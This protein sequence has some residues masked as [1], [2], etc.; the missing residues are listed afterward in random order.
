MIRPRTHPP[1]ENESKN[2]S[3]ATTRVFFKARFTY[4]HILR[5][6]YRN[7]E[8]IHS[9][10]LPL[11]RRCLPDLYPWKI[12]TKRTRTF[13]H[14]FR[15]QGLERTAARRGM[16]MPSAAGC[17]TQAPHGRSGYPRNRETCHSGV[18]ARAKAGI[19]GPLPVAPHKSSGGRRRLYDVADLSRWTI[20]S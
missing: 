7:E 12:P 9:Y 2:G 16:Q 13:G 19:L 17:L 15:Q 18:F 5:C 11:C 10:L 1:E 4:F 3:S 8:S 20:A 6:P 14:P